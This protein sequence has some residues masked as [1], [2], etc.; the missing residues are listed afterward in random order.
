MNASV[1]CIVLLVGQAQAS[2]TGTIRDSETGTPVAGATVELRDARR[3]SISGPDGSY[4]LTGITAGVRHLGVSRLGYVSRTLHVFVP[5]EGSIAVDVGLAPAPIPLTPVEAI[6]GP[7]SRDASEAGGDLYPRIGSRTLSQASVRSDPRLAEPDFFEALAGDGVSLDPESPSGLHVHGGAADQNLF[8]LDGVPIYSPYHATGTFSALNPDAI[9]RLDLHAG[10]PP[11]AWDGALSGY[12]HASTET[13]SADAFRVRGAATATGARLTVDG[14]LAGGAGLLLSGRWNHPGFVAPPGEDAYVRGA[15]T[16]H[17]VKLEAPTALGRFQ[18]LA[19]GSSSKLRTSSVLIPDA[20]EGFD[21]G[22]EVAVSDA[23]TPRNL[24]A[25]ESG[26]Y[27]IGWVK[28]FGDRLSINANFWRADLDVDTRWWAVDAP[29]S[30][31]SERQTYGSQ[32]MLVADGQATRSRFG[33]GFESEHTSYGVEP[34]GTSPVPEGALLRA[35]ASPEIFSAF[36]EHQRELPGRVELLL[37]LRGSLV[38]DHQPRLAPRVSLRW[39]LTQNVSVG[40]GFARTHQWVHSLRNPESVADNL[41]ASQLPLAVEAPGVPIARSDQLSAKLEAETPFGLRAGFKAY[42][43]DLDGLVLVAPATGQPFAVDGLA[44]GTAR[45]WGGA[46]VLD[47]GRARYRARVDYGFGSIEYRLEEGGYRP[48][49]G[50][51]HA[52]SASIGYHPSAT[53]LL[54]SAVRA[55]FGRPTTRVE[56]PFE[57]EPCTI[58]DAGCEVQGSPERAA[59]PL[60]GDRLPTYVRLDLGIRKH[61]HPRLMG[62]EG[63]IT[64]FITVSNVLGRRNVLGYSVDPSTGELSELPMRP[65]TPISVGLEWG[66]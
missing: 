1:L 60:G 55:E 52:L 53:L 11:S 59:G 9:A 4:A 56:G 29:L 30:A 62:R 58:I 39:P 40:L 54:R 10:A 3:I 20:G 49:Y 63:I 31:A 5:A 43:R 46:V 25:W 21:S 16:D 50:I 65:F 33:L 66:F 51:G 18:L 45:A 64:G 42:A 17:I 26:S 48:A 15:F 27:G 34:L 13:P 57:W 2:V 36:A 44:V 12:F 6:S 24:L 38:A 47:L 22:A 8:T 37:G 7:R 61:W 35:E 14:P 23:S 19:Y 28:S 41:F 32:V